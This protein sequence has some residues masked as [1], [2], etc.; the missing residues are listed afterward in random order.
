MCMEILKINQGCHEFRLLRKVI[1]LTSVPYLIEFQ[2]KIF[3]PFL[4]LI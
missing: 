2:L 3:L 4:V 1:Q